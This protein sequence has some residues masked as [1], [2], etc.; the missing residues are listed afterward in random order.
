MKTCPQNGDGPVPKMVTEC[1]NLSPKLGQRVPKMVTDF[2]VSPTDPSPKLGHPY[3]TIP[4]SPSSD[5]LPARSVLKTSER[6]TRTGRWGGGH[7]NL[8]GPLGPDR[9]Q[10]TKK[11][12][13]SFGRKFPWGGGGKSWQS[14]IPRPVREQNSRK[15]RLEL[16]KI[17]RGEGGA[18]RISTALSVQTGGSKF[19]S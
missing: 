16:R 11:D 10:R 1:V 18:G 9:R 7:V 19:S 13:A 5:S 6:E 4:F 17:Q 8:S 14:P 15:A 2:T 3:L 12:A